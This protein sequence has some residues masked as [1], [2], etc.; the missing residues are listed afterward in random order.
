MFI[1]VE[2]TV[3]IPFFLQKTAGE[4]PTHI[5]TKDNQKLGSEIGLNLLDYLMPVLS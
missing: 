5:G 4:T 2:K 1:P 3:V